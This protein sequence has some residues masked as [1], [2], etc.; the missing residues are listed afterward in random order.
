M[1][2]DALSRIIA[3]R[4]LYKTYEKPG[5]TE[6]ERQLNAIKGE[7]VVLNNENAY[8]NQAISNATGSPYLKDQDFY[9]S[10]V[11]YNSAEET[12]WKEVKTYEEQYDRVASFNLKKLNII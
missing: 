4:S 12:E 7:L 3:N 9:K 10:D 11:L 1:S 6:T 2:S 8:K 5:S